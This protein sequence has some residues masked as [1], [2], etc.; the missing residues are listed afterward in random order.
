MCTEAS[1]IPLDPPMPE[2]LAA[3]ME[4]VDTSVPLLCICAIGTV[5]A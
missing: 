1:D 4:S 3:I 2:L 5:Y